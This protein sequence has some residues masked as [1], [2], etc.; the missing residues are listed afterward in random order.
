MW[1]TRQQYERIIGMGSLMN[2]E[3][4]ADLSRDWN[5]LVAA[6]RLARR[7]RFLE[8]ETTIARL[9]LDGPLGPAALDLKAKICAQQG[10]MLEAQ[11]CWTE[12][13]RRSPSNASYRRSLDYLA[14]HLCYSRLSLSTIVLAVLAA[15][16]VIFFW[17]IGLKL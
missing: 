6:A 15:V 1:V 16:I 5:V 11:F 14:R 4:R 3:C 9:P 10:R 17:F 8:A 12:A 2:K 7:G 13:V